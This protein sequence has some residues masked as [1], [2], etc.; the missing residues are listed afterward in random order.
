MIHNSGQQMNTW[1]R[2]KGQDLKLG[3]GFV[4]IYLY[5][6]LDEVGPLHCPFHI[7]RLHL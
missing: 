4:V 1:Q 3:T 6:A 2:C 5:I 7:P